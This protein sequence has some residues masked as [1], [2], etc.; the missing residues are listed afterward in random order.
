MKNYK[1]FH[2]RFMKLNQN[3]F[4]RHYSVENV[5]CLMLVACTLF[6]NLFERP[7]NL[8]NRKNKIIKKE[9]LDFDFLFEHIN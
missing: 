9:N 4:E 5:L 7:L 8:N 1:L 2:I 6:I 3:K